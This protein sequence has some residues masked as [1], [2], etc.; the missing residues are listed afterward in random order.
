MMSSVIEQLY[1]SYIY[2]LYNR[3]ITVVSVYNS[4]ITV[5]YVIWQ[6]T[7]AVIWLL[8]NSNICYNIYNGCITV[9]SRLYNSYIIYIWQQTSAAI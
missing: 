8:Y 5:I 9:L 2:M 6:Q 3:Y 1:N 4:Y 7:S